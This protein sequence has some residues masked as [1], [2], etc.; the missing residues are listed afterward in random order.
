MTK[1]INYRLPNRNWLTIVKSVARFNIDIRIHSFSY[2]GFIKAWIVCTIV[3][4]YEKLKSNV[5]RTFII[6]ITITMKSFK[7]FYYEQY[8]ILCSNQ[9]HERALNAKLYNS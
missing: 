2:Y 1:K 9:T 5:Y 8:I 7:H 3:R 4:N 6:I